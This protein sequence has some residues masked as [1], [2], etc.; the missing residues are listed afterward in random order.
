MFGEVDRPGSTVD[1]D[2]RQRAASFGIGERLHLLGHR[3]PIAGP[4]AALDAL[5]VTALNEPFGRTLIEAMDL[6]V[7]VVATRHGGNVEAIEDGSTGFLVPPNDPAAFAGPIARL[8]QDG[9]LRD[10]ITSAARQAVHTTYGLQDSVRGVERCYS[11]LLSRRARQA[12][13]AAT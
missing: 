5:V 11:R 8:V 9:A 10:R 1:R 7:P 2:A 12:P 3:I 6:G 13:A 4:M